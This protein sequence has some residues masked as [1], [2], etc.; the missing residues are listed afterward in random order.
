VPYWLEGDDFADDP[1]WEVLAGG[2][3]D[4]V[5][6]LQ[7]A[8]SR[9]KAKAAHLLTDGY[10]TEKTAL[11]Y[12]R[13]RRQV[14]DRLCTAVLARPAKVHRQGD[15]CECL[16]DAPWIEGYAYRIHAFLK[17]NPS[18]REYNRN[19]A[20]RRDL[21]DPRLKSM[22]YAR[23]G[24]CCRYCR[25]GP[26][27]PK[28]GRSRDRRKVLHYDHVDPDVPAGPEGRNLVVSCGRCNEHK[29]RRTPAEAD[30][31]LLAE[32]AIEQATLWRV[33]PQQLHDL[34]ADP[35]TAPSG[36]PA[37]QR[38]ISA[39]TDQ[40][41]E[42][43]KTA[44][45]DPIAD[46]NGGRNN[47]LTGS[48]QPTATGP[49]V[50]PGPDQRPAPSGSGRGGPP[51]STAGPPTAYDDQ[52]ARTAQHPDIYHRRSRASPA[53]LPGLPPP[54]YVWP[55]GSVPVLPPD[56]PLEPDRPVS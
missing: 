13:G 2:A 36:S 31:V 48:D 7:A 24:G 4:R 5:D 53:G 41:S 25:S 30:M 37:D 35:A 55:S 12:C 1:T 27:S 8:Y 22:V 23:D 45:T 50:K 43:N 21:D 3:P 51:G 52:P 15:Q 32:P 38:P 19:Q 46:P 54:E 18:R 49:P 6:A 39:E 9:L 56:D 10:L 28:A 16:G 20:Q 47:D 14:L 33:R 17:R 34:P 40:T 42:Q 29:G 11:L 44:T 26:L